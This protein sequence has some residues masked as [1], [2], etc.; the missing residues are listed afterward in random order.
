MTETFIGEALKIQDITYKGSREEYQINDPN[1]HILVLDRNY[2]DDSYLAFNL[3]YLDSLGKHERKGLVKDMQEFD[4]SVMD[5]RGV[6]G[7]LIR[8]F[9]L[10]YYPVSADQKKKRYEEL[11]RKFPALLKIIRRYKH[12]A[13]KKM[14]LWAKIKRWFK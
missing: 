12:S 5:L 4:A 13:L 3:N 1:P 14:G 11:V 8:F 7:W 10:S 9:R 2:K 6:K